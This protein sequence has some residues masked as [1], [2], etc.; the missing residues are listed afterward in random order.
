MS[1]FSLS[2]LLSNRSAVF[3]L[4]LALFCLDRL[5]KYWVMHESF[6]P[7]K[8]FSWLSFERE[9]NTGVS[10]SLFAQENGTQSIL[11]L[12]SIG[13]TIAYIFY[14]TY[15]RLIAGK[16]I[17]GEAMVIAGALSNSVDR[18]LYGAVVDCIACTLFGYALPVFN[19]ADSAIVAGVALMALELINESKSSAC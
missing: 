11:L 17:W 1:S 5:T 18:V 4:S 16:S 12:L 9:L 8:V 19:V 15:T 14:G 7:Y 6:Y 2:R 13:V 3:A 10:F